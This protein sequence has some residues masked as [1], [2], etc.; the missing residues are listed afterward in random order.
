MLKLGT[1]LSKSELQSIH[2]GQTTVICN[3]SDGESWLAN[4]NT[5]GV[6]A[7]LYISCKGQGG[8]PF[9]IEVPNQ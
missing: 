9:I 1:V 8:R 4:T 2:G 7:S 3:F 5:P 6:T